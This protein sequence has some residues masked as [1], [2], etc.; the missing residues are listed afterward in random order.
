MAH[1]YFL[2]PDPLLLDRFD[3]R[4]SFPETVD[5]LR[6]MIIDH[7]LA[8][9]NTRNVWGPGEL[10][11]ALEDTVIG[12]GIPD[13]GPLATHSFNDRFRLRQL[14][15]RAITTFEPR[16]TDVVVEDGPMLDGDDR[17]VFQIRGSLRL[18]ETTIDIAQDTV[19]DIASRRFESRK[20][21]FSP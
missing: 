6:K 2:P 7:L 15:A 3:E 18:P 11:S 4:S 19:L 13:H 1:S 12:W 20:R 14:I 16:L 21:R 8:L 10:P 17:P 9:L 5:D